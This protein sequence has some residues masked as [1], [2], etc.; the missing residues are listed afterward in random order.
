VCRALAITSDRITT[1]EREPLDAGAA[2][3]ADNKELAALRRAFNQAVRARRLPP[4][5][6]P[7]TPRLLG[8]TPHDFRRTAARNLIRARVPQPTW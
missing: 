4:T 3:A 6:K 5:A 2:R 7:V 8:H 1:Y